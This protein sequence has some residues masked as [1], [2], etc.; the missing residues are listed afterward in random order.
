MYA[1]LMGFEV[2]KWSPGSTLIKIAPG[3]LV[4]FK[5]AL[6]NDP[7][8]KGVLVVLDCMLWESYISAIFYFCQTLIRHCT[9]D[10][11]YRD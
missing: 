6:F 3:S 8:L 7:F 5:F 10:K 2:S 4:G 11:C 1:M 9:N